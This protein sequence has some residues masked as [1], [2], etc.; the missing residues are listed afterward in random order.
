[1]KMALFPMN[2][3]P[4]ASGA[5]V[6]SKGFSPHHS[7]TVVYFSVEKIEETLNK[8]QEKGGKTLLPKTAIGEYGFIAHFEDCEG[9]QVAL[10]S[11]NG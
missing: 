7:G 10:H 9:N 6:Q 2:E 8:I 5:L 1:M 4:G 11:M 3:G